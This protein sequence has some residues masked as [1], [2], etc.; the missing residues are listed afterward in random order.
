MADKILVAYGT[1]YGATAEIAD[2]IAT[3]LREAGFG[4]DLHRAR[5]VRSFDGYRAVVLGSAV[6][7]AR[8]RPDALRLLRRQRA[9]LARSDVWLF[10]SGPVG[11][12][13]GEDDEKADRWLRP[14]RV[15]AL[16]KEIGVQ[17][18]VVFGGKVAEDGGMM[19]RNM[20]KGTPEELRDRRDWDA[21]RAWATKIAQTIR[22]APPQSGHRQAS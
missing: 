12:Q 19:R 16:A 15:Q 9:V 5:E 20:A 10:S 11:E 7:M 14:K 13:T 22:E 8:W 6:Y 2:A 17:E 3:T 1:K 21:I 18:H 4:V